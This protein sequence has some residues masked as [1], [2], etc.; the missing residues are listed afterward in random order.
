MLTAWPSCIEFSK[1]CYSI[2]AALLWSSYLGDLPI[3]LLTIPIQT[4]DRLLEMWALATASLTVLDDLTSTVLQ[5][6]IDIAMRNNRYTHI[7]QIKI[8][9]PQI[10]NQFSLCRQNL[11]WWKKSLMLQHFSFF[12][13]FCL[14]LGQLKNQHHHKMRTV[15]PWWFQ[16]P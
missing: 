6:W 15:F 14:M 8:P 9:C 5:T 1:H 4:G 16:H 10:G 11:E 2:S 13:L 12:F 3:K 7:S